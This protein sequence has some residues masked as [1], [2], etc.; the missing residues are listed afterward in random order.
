MGRIGSRNREGMESR[1]ERLWLFATHPLITF[2]LTILM[3][4]NLV[5]GL[6]LFGLITLVYGVV[7]IL[8]SIPWIIRA[9]LKRLRS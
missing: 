3:V 1:L 9:L 6:F 5:L 7:L 8:I 2:G 4:L